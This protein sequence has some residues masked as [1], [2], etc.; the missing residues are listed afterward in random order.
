MIDDKDCVI[1]GKCI[2][3]WIGGMINIFIYKEFDL[4]F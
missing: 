3:D 1:D 2:L 4:L